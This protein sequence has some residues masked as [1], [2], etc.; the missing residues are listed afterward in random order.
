[1]FAFMKSKQL[2]KQICD[3]KM[4]NILNENKGVLRMKINEILEL[5]H[6]SE[7]R[8]NLLNAKLNSEKKKK[9]ELDKKYKTILKKSSH[10]AGYFLSIVFLFVG[11]IGTPMFLMNALDGQQNEGFLLFLENIAFFTFIPGGIVG[12][13]VGAF[14][15]LVLNAILDAPYKN[16]EKEYYSKISV[17]NKAISD[18]EREIEEENYN[19]RQLRREHDYAKIYDIE[20]NNNEDIARKYIL[21][22]SECS[23]SAYANGEITELYNQMENLSAKDKNSVFAYLYEWCEQNFWNDKHNVFGTMFKLLQMSVNDGYEPAKENLTM[24]LDEI[25]NDINR[26]TKSTYVHGGYFD[27]VMK[28]LKAIAENGD[29]R[30]QTL[31]KL[32]Q[33]KHKEVSVPKVFASDI[34]SRIDEQKKTQSGGTDVE[35]VYVPDVSGV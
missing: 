27:S 26:E 30:A 6:K 2:V 28:K 32:G 5:V 24:I 31:L 29:D 25:E 16:G 4:F 7:Q 10:D 8:I 17:V 33:Q 23:G 20:L 21:L 18:I 35:I 3:L 13:Y 1:M 15:G 12:Y 14:L 34:Q 9:D 11:L 19:Y 22:K